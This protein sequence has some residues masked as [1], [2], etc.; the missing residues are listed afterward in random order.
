MPSY[1]PCKWNGQQVACHATKRSYCTLMSGSVLQHD[2]HLRSL[3]TLVAACELAA[4]R[5]GQEWQP[6]QPQLRMPGST[7]DGAGLE[8]GWQFPLGSAAIPDGLLQLETISEEVVPKGNSLGSP[9]PASVAQG[10]CALVFQRSASVPQTTKPGVTVLQAV[11]QEA[12]PT[13]Y[14]RHK[15][16]VRVFFLSLCSKAVKQEAAPTKY[17][18]T[19][20]R[21]AYCFAAWWVPLVCTKPTHHHLTIRQ[22]L[23]TGTFR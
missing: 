4:E 22:F 16:K 23:T 11:K 10:Q 17:R 8:H 21:C 3:E 13:K 18:P 14:R 19:R 12:A 9:I 5:D 7:A 6:L 20:A 1:V 2:M 15:S